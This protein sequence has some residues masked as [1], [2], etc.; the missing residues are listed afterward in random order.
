MRF[1]TRKTEISQAMMTGIVREILKEYNL[2]PMKLKVAEA[3]TGMLE[4]WIHDSNHNNIEVGYNPNIIAFFNLEEIK[5]LMHHE[6]FHPLTMK[7]DNMIPV[8][9]NVQ[10]EMRDYLSDFTVLYHEYINYA[11]YLAYYRDSRLFREYK[12]GEI[13]N[14]E[15]IIQTLRYLVQNGTLP[16]P[17]HIHQMVI[18]ILIDA[19]FFFAVD[20]Q[21]FQEFANRINVQVLTQYYQWIVEDLKFIHELQPA[22]TSMFELTQLIGHVTTSVIVENI[23]MNSVITFSPNSQQRFT[24]ACDHLPEGPK[25]TIANRWL[26]RAPRRMQSRDTPFFS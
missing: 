4:V 11:E 18:K 1:A 8:P 15:I 5:A 16:T 10:P 2:R 12:V 17:L 20:T 21:P 23:I 7:T 13:T 9:D 6:I 22:T 26:E 19:V 24:D 3:K 14:Y 25:R